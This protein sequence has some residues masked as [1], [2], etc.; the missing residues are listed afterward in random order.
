MQL[1]ENKKLGENNL[2]DS[3]E[4]IRAK[5][6]EEYEELITEIDKEN[7]LNISLEVFDLIQV[8][9]RVL[10]LLKKNKVNLTV[11]NKQHNKKLKKRKWEFVDIVGIEEVSR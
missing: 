3:W 9:I 7:L 5:L 4:K 2:E 8:C 1:G 11:E 10:I 6:K